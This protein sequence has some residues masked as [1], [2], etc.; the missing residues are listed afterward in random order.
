MANHDV[1]NPTFNSDLRK[2]EITD[3]GHADV[4]NAVIKQLINND[5][6][7]NELLSEMGL[8]IDDLGTNKADNT[9]NTRKTTA[10]TV[11]G[12]INELSDGKINKN[13]FVSK[14][15]YAVTSGTS[16]AYTVTTNPAP[17]A[18]GDGMLIT[19][20][21][22]VDC[23]S[24]PTLNWND[25]GASVIVNQDG[26]VISAGDIKANLPLSLV[27][28]GSNFFIRSADQKNKVISA[29]NKGQLV[30]T[31]MTSLQDALNVLNS[32]Y[33]VDKSTAIR[34]WSKNWSI[35]PT[36]GGAS[37]QW[38]Y[39]HI[40]PDKTNLVVIVGLNYWGWILVLDSTTGGTIKSLYSWNA[41][42]TSCTGLNKL[43]DGNILFR[44][45]VSGGYVIYKTNRVSGTVEQIK[46]TAYDAYGAVQDV[47]GNYYIGEY[48]GSAYKLN[49]LSSA[50][51]L[52]FSA[53]F[54]FA[55]FL[56]MVNNI[57]YTYNGKNIYSVNKNTGAITLV[58]A[59]TGSNNIT[60][61][62]FD[63][64]NNCIYINDQTAGTVT[65]VNLNTMQPVYTATKT[66]NSYTISVDNDI[67][68]DGNLNAYS[69]NGIAVPK[70]S[71][72]YNSTNEPGGYP[73]FAEVV[74]GKGYLTTNPTDYN[75]RYSYQ[76]RRTITG[77]FL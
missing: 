2:F 46:S 54:T 6:S 47:D 76:Y 37:I 14:N 45:D 11:T 52:I 38:F 58:Y 9:D 43:S 41:S 7:L 66:Y 59:Y 71:P 27:R 12:A 70:T 72:T 60:N 31:A 44:I 36:Y 18:Y 61:I 63:E 35:G 24:N 49:K 50:K 23:T 73:L 53:T 42:G 39:V 22:H 15:N 8:D 21:P 64:L 17:T 74:D 56:F 29:I 19:I 28:V 30:T 25:L 57:L 34:G 16:A 33:I 3:S 48:D 5:V 75:Y 62:V 10:K 55:P 13:D 51:A 68:Y 4:F 65:K 32:S 77:K 67:L 26:S 40:T 1:S 20:I 69:S